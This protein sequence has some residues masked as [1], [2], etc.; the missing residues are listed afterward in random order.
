MNTQS[1]V[2]TVEPGLEG[3]GQGGS[4]V[5]WEL[6]VVKDAKPRVDA[7]ID[8]LSATGASQEKVKRSGVDNDTFGVKFGGNGGGV[9]GQSIKV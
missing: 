3:A 1:R 8:S 5:V 6:R 4:D 9:R 7:M 2:V